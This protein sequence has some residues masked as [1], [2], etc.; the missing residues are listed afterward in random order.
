MRVAGQ[1]VGIRRMLVEAP[2]RLVERHRK[3][4]ARIDVAQEILAI[5]QMLL[6]VSRAG[7]EPRKVVER[8]MMRLEIDGVVLAGI[9]D[10]ALLAWWP[11]TVRQRRVPA[12]CIPGPADALCR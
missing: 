5:F 2:D 11:A 8:L 10:R 9:N 6:P 12:A 1:Q 7:R 3:Q 4:P